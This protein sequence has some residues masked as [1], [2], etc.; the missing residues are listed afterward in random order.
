MS[1]AIPPAARDALEAWLTH[2]RAI[3]GASAHT[4]RA[5][6]ADVT[7]WLAFLAGHLG[8]GYGLKRLASVPHADLRAWMAHE[9]ARGL[10]ARS[11]A[12]SLSAVRQFTGWLAEREASTR[13]PSSRPAAPSSAASCRGLCRRRMRRRFCPPWPR[14]PPKTGSAPAT[15]PW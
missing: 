5:Y 6:T 1:L 4:I 3:E 11:L 2:Q 10:G 13:P 12:R 14:T 7:G 9:R 15:S 8:E